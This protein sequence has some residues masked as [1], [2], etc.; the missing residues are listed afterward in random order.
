MT[1]TTTSAYTRALGARLLSEANDLKRTV[2]ALASEM[3]LPLDYVES[4]IAGALQPAEYRSLFQAVAERYPIAF[5]RLW[6]EPGDTQ[7]GALHLTAEEARASSRIF[8]RADR[9]GNLTPYYEYRDSAM[10]RSAPF[11]PEW[12]RELRVVSDANP[13][14]PD[15]AYN[16][17]HFLHQT[18]F[19]VGPVNFYWDVDGQKRSAELTT[20]DSNYITPFWPHSFASRDDSQLTLIVAVTYGGEVARGREELARLGAASLPALT[21][22]MRNEA[23]AHAALLNR[24][25]EN[26]V[27]PRARFIDRCVL[28]GM[29]AE[30]VEALLDGSILP[31]NSE[32]AAMAALLAITPRDLLPP[33]RRADEEVVVLRRAD[34]EVYPYPGPQNPAYEITRLAR[35]RQQPYLKSF[36]LRALPGR[37]GAELTVRLHQ[38]GYNFGDEPV[39][40]TVRHGDSEREIVLAPADSAYLLPLTVCRFDAMGDR[41]GDIYMVGVQ[42]DLHADAVFE[43]SGMAPRGLNRVAGETTRWF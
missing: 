25:L 11:R 24:H 33:T 1:T 41:P 17:G 4:A 13:V 6:M 18:T 16:K 37:R 31:T 27:L 14:N 22:E 5:G 20:G 23:G 30:R 21:L 8:S 19:F 9:A 35:S 26:E 42:G 36:I 7:A 43:L 2:D 34:A 3:G 40:L 15:V 29:P 38:F 10:S 32:T 28:S 12:I 39:R